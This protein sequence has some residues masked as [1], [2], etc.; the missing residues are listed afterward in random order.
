MKA[1]LFFNG[2]RKFFFADRDLTAEYVKNNCAEELAHVIRIADETVNQSFK[3]DLRWD[4]EQTTKS[5]VFTGKID[6][7]YQPGDDPEFIYAFNRMRFW[8]CLGQ[9]YA[10]TKNEKY[11]DAFAAQLTDWIDSVP[12]GDPANEKA[13]RTI[14]TGLRLEYWLKAM[15]YFKGSP[16]ITDDVMDKF[17]AS[18]TEHAEFLMTVWNSFNLM[19][20]W[21][22]LANHGLFMAGVM[23]PET[24][25][26]AAYTAEALRR[27]TAELGIQIYDDGVQWE[28]SPMYH[29]EVTHDYLDVLILAQ[30]NNIRLTED[31][32]DKVH[33]MALVNVV[34]QKPDGSELSMGD[35]DEIDVRDI[36]TTAACVFNDPVLKGGGYER[37]DFDSAWDVGAECAGLY[38]GMEPR[39]PESLTQQLPASGNFYFRSGYDDG[40]VFFH[41]HCGTLG[42]GHGHSDQLHIDL[43]ANGE[44]IFVDAG[45]Y[46][47]VNKPERFEFKDGSAHNTCLVDGR[48][49]YT[50]RDSWECGH[51]DRAVNRVCK[52]TARYAYAEGGHLGFMDTAG[53]FA[54]RRVV[55]I[56]PDIFIIADEMYTA[57]S[58]SY[59]NLLHGNYR[60]NLVKD[61]ENRFRYMSSRNNTEVVFAGSVPHRTGISKTKM[62]RHYNAYDENSTL[63]TEWS[64]TGF[65]CLFSVISV[66]RP[67]SAF[68]SVQVE[69]VPVKSNFKNMVFSDSQIQALKVTKGGRSCLVVIAH[70]EYAS[71]TDTFRA[72]GC[73][74]F[75]NVTVFELSAGENETGTMLVV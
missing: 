13:W 58:H 57:G 60:G 29:N 64:A 70:E 38:D 54:N 73:T 74:G 9:A 41:F 71:P 55:Y 34:W 16:A 52:D 11:A 53:V 28:Q 1:D 33:K 23:L 5:V 65:S 27:L 37:L 2:N 24:E 30:R 45:R 36:T 48:G 59:E 10:V 75:G 18:V 46:T 49:C 63:K 19:S 42:A 51:L 40:A 44:D 25:R 47:Y 69:L 56:K 62:S 39:H 31:F 14:E 8:I 3:F 4:M 12:H 72:E 22:V 21:G 43:Y 35:S 50:Y 7:L 32:I 68:C 26:T 20:N 15:C 67:D 17:T 61:D 66:N 6:W